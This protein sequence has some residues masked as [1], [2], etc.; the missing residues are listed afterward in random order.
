[1]ANYRFETAKADASQTSG[2]SHTLTVQVYDAL[3]EEILAGTIG[4][5]TRLVRRTL[6]KRLGVS[7]VPVAEALLRLEMDG[8]VESRPLLGSRVRVLTVEEAREDAVLREAIEC[9]AARVCAEHG[10][11]AA[12][13]KLLSEAQ[14]VDRLMAQGAPGSKLGMRAH[15]AFHVN[16][17]RCGGFGRLAEEL[18]R[19]WFRR[20]MRLTWVKATHYKAVPDR[21]H[22]QLVE[23]ILTCDPELAERKMREHVLY[24]NEDDA[25]AVQYVSQVA[26]EEDDDGPKAKLSQ[27]SS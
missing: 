14:L 3:R 18:Q 1:M 4:P 9:Q 17:A 24:G 11:E 23:A 5:G 15:F 16:L 21:W 22:E 10:T 27:G 13:G 19:V 6:S 8:L 12:L 26:S 7:P 20:V 25:L 2:V